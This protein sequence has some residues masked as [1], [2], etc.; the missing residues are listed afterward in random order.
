MFK[1]LF[2]LL[3]PDSVVHLP[4]L[5]RRYKLIVSIILI[6]I[7]FD[8]DYAITTISINMQEGTYILSLAALIHISLLFAIK[9][10]L[11]LI[12]VSNIYIATGVTAVMVSII[13]SGGYASP[14]LPWLASSPIMALL[15]AG[16]RTGITWM[17]IN[18]LLTIFFGISKSMHI[19]FPLH[20]DLSWRDNLNLNCAFGLIMII[21]F[22]SLVFENGKNSAMKRLEEHSLLLSEEK[23]KNALYEISQEIHDGMGQTLSVIKLNLHLLDTTF[24]EIPN[25]KLKETL[26]LA[27]KAIEDLRNISNN[28]YTESLREFDLANALIEDITHIRKLGKPHIELSLLGKPYLVEPRSAFIL[29]RVTREA[30]NNSLR[31]AQANN[32][33]VTLH[34]TNPFQIVIKDDGIGIKNA[35]LNSSGQG[36]LNM[37]DRLALLGGKLSIESTPEKGTT[38]TASIKTTELS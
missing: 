38:I 17:I 35:G 9:K 36:M 32:I 8:L 34:F 20:Y 21:F 1:T 29:Y 26:Q 11:P 31:H 4:E 33:T 14:V 22:V 24:K 37:R 10:R 2:Q 5:L 6:T 25:E 28:L 18:T 13:Y 16:R 7:L 19:E 23:K 27:G 30:I 12:W 15:M 3:I